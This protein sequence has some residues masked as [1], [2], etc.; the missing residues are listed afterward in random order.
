M[1][2]TRRSATDLERR[3]PFGFWTIYWPEYLWTVPSVWSMFGDGRPRVDEYLDDDTLV[4]R[5]ELPGID[6]EKDVEITIGDGMLH[7]HAERRQ[8]EKLEDKDMYRSELRYGVFTRTLPLPAGVG[9]QDIDA[10]YKAGILEIRI[11]V[12]QKKAA[13]KVPVRAS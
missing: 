10:S 7:I 6:P 11:P 5:A 2:L 8:E 1:A 3:D 12:D 9:E 13:T 4:I